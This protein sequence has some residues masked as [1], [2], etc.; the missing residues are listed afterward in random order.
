M[1]EPV[2]RRDEAALE[3]K[4]RLAALGLPSTHWAS[5]GTPH[6]LV[7]P[8]ACKSTAGGKVGFPLKSSIHPVSLREEA[9]IAEMWKRLEC[10]DWESP[11]PADL[12]EFLEGALTEDI[13][14][15][16]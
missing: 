4:L 11:L 2:G 14:L 16:L 3:R 8:Q 10:C 15:V 1:G 13:K 9:D 12:R 7:K 6:T 5:L